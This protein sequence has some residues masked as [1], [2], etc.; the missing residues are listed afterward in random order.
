MLMFRVEDMTCGHCA[1]AIASAVAEV[2]REARVEVNVG[3]KIVS[4]SGDTPESDI[5]EAIR[6]A[7]Y[8]PQRVAEAAPRAPATRGGC[9][10][11]ARKQAV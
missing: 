4:V 1:S 11:A 2:D 8:T 3:D 10:C 6:Q 5:A 7:G 9:C